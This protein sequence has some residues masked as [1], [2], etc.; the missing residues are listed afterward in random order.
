[1]IP[2]FPSFCRMSIA[3]KD[4]FMAIVT[5]WPCYS[6]FN[7]VSLLAWNIDDTTEVATL[8]KNLLIRQPDYITNEPVLSIIGNDDIE[9]YLLLM[10]SFEPKYIQFQHV[11]EFT[12]QSIGSSRQFTISPQRDHHDY[13]LNAREQLTMKG[14]RFSDKRNHLRKYQRLY[15]EHTRVELVDMHHK[16]TVKAIFELLA[17]W[18]ENSP[19]QKAALSNEYIALKRLFAH[20]DQLNLYCM[21]VFVENTLRAFAINEVIDD[22]FELGHF[23]KADY[24]YKHILTYLVDACMWHIL[25]GG[26]SYINIEQDLGLPHLRAAKTHLVPDYFLKK[27]TIDL[28]PI[29]IPSRSVRMLPHGAAT[30]RHAL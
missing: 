6:D 13:V 3:I 23:I 24:R 20:A 1:M 8:G 9:R 2:A 14:G 10:R 21:C 27:Y 12:V 18:T 7:F 5:K 19:Q 16:P 30:G 29:R 28:T 17:L 22:V 4:E 25:D 26:R 11:P 15:G